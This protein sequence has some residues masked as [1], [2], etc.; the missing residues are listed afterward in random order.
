MASHEVCG[1]RGSAVDSADNAAK[2]RAGP[3]GPAPA[4]WQLQNS[5]LNQSS[6]IDFFVFS[7]R[8]ASFAS[9]SAMQSPLSTMAHDRYSLISMMTA[10]IALPVGVFSYL[11]RLPPKPPR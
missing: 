4:Y 2:Q 6:L 1:R 5:E 10:R 11:P 8:E 9:Y 7:R 3:S